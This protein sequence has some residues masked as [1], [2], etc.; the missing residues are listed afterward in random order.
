MPSAIASTDH[1]RESIRKAIESTDDREPQ[2]VVSDGTGARGE[3][4]VTDHTRERS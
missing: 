3:E 4:Q 2:V 1:A